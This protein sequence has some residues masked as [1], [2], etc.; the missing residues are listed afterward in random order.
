MR[1]VLLENWQYKQF[2]YPQFV[3]YIMSI[4]K[5]KHC[6]KVHKLNKHLQHQQQ[7][8]PS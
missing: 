1:N 3:N 5:D 7:N 8:L 4:V 2:I 6:K